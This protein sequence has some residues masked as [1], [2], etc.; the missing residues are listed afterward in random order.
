MIAMASIHVFEAQLRF[1]CYIYQAYV[2]RIGLRKAR[3]AE[4]AVGDPHNCQQF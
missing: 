1:G 4:Q 3:L 2:G